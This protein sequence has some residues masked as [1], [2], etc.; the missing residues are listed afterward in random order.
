MRRE[1][2]KVRREYS[3]DGKTSESAQNAEASRVARHGAL[4]VQ[5]AWESGA[6]VRGEGID[7][8]STVVSICS[9]VAASC[10]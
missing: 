3:K 6:A 5:A 1:W 2:S 10:C 7:T 9:S 4:D 8:C